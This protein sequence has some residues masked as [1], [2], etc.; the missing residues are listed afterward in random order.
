[1]NNL[2]IITDTQR[3]ALGLEG[4]YEEYNYD[5]RSNLFDIFTRLTS[6]RYPLVSAKLTLPTKEDAIVF[7]SLLKACK[8]VKVRTFVRENRV[9]IRNLSES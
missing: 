5:V 7:A 3:I 8:K 2:A 4:H 9:H 6:E 1:M